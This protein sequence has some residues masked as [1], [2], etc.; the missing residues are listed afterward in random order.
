MIDLTNKSVEDVNLL[1]QKYT[2][3]LQVSNVKTN[4]DAQ[5]LAIVIDEGIKYIKDNYNEISTDLKTWCILV[6]KHKI[7]KIKTDI[8]IKKIIDVF[9][10]YWNNEYQSYCDDLGLSASDFDRDYG[11]I[12]TFI[13][14]KI[15]D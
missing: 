5:M 2:P 1:I 7:S 10:T 6:L 9:I 15:G 14:K 3:V 11:F 12:Q 4:T 8:D 13:H